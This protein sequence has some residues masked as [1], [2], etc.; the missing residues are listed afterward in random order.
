MKLHNWQR[1]LESIETRD[2]WR[3]IPESVKQLHQIF[4][5]NGFKLYVVGGAVRDFIRGEKPKDFDLCT[6]AI[7]D[8]VVEILSD[9]FRITKQGASFGVVV[10]YT[11]DQPLGME[12]ATMREDVYGEKLGITR[13]PDVKFSTI[14]K[15]VERRDITFNALFYDLD[16]R[17]IVDLVNGIKDI[18]DGVVRFIGDPELRIQEDPLRILRVVRFCSRYEF[19]L[20]K[21]TKQ[22]IIDNKSDLRIITAERIWATTG[23]NTGEIMKG[24]KQA[25]N[26]TDYMRLM[27]E[28][29]IFEEI[30][31]GLKINKNVINSKYLQIH[32]AN[33]L[34]NNDV[35]TLERTLIRKFKFETS[36][37]REI[38]FLIS[39][40]NL[41]LDNFILLHK[42]MITF[43]IEKKMVKSWLKLNKSM[44]DSIFEAFLS[45]SPSVSSEGLMRQGFKGADLGKEI[46][47]REKIEI[48]KLSQSI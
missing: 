34:L 25:A 2:M 3:I 37:A 12:I 28:L 38:T 36:L 48:A 46:Q 19:E 8:K 43:K 9:K 33:L 23:D 5:S 27:Q 42:K 11:D 10:V 18:E 45:W 47:R 16:K 35:N 26:F 24:W 1:F 21:L 29:G 14:E 20:D 41:N 31:S 30:L 44:S 7:P 15:D 6:D 4:K 17:E 40:L 32:L 13:N 22:A 39:L